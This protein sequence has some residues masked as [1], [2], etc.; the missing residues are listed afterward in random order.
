MAS[1]PSPRDPRQCALPSKAPS[2]SKAIQNTIQARAPPQSQ[3][4]AM[5]N[6]HA[7]VGGN[8]TPHHRNG[9]GGPTPSS[10][11]SSAYKS[12]SHSVVSSDYELATPYVNAAYPIGASTKNVNDMTT[13]TQHLQ[14]S[15]TSEFSARKSSPPMAASH[16]SSFMSTARYQE[17]KLGSQTGEFFRVNDENNPNDKGNKINVGQEQTLFDSFT[18][19]SINSSEASSLSIH[20]ESPLLQQQEQRWGNINVL[21]NGQNNVEAGKQTELL[22]LRTNPLSTGPTTIDDDDHSSITNSLSPSRTSGRNYGNSFQLEQHQDRQQIV[23]VERPHLLIYEQNASRASNN[24]NNNP[25][26][27]ADAS[28]LHSKIRSLDTQHKD[29]LSENNALASQ[30]KLD[31]QR[32]DTLESSEEEARQEAALWEARWRDDFGRHTGGGDESSP[33]LIEQLRGALLQKSKEEYG[34]LRREFVALTSKLEKAKGSYAMLMAENEALRE[35]VREA[36]GTGTMSHWE[37]RALDSEKDLMK[38][39]GELHQLMKEKRALE[40]RVNQLLEKSERSRK[41]FD[42][43]QKKLDEQLKNERDVHETKM[44]QITSEAAQMIEEETSKKNEELV[45]AKQ[46]NIVLKEENKAAGA[47]NEKLAERVVD[48]ERKIN[49]SLSDASDLRNSL[50]DAETAIPRLETE[51]NN[52]REKVDKLQND[53]SLYLD[54]VQALSSENGRLKLLVPRLEEQVTT[55][56]AENESLQRDNSDMKSKI[57]EFERKSTNLKSDNLA[58]KQRLDK[59]LEMVKTLQQTDSRTSKENSLLR[60]SIDGLEHKL[61]TVEAHLSDEREKVAF[62]DS[63]RDEAEEKASQFESQVKRLE[64]DLSAANQL[65]ANKRE[66]HLQL[67]N[68]IQELKKNISS[69]REEISAA[70]IARSQLELELKQREDECSS[71]RCQLDPTLKE[72]YR[73][74]LDNASLIE[75]IECLK[76]SI[77]SNSSLAAT[78]WGSEEPPES[79]INRLEEKN[80][81]LTDYIATLQKDLTSMQLSRPE[82]K[83]T[84]NESPMIGNDGTDTT[85]LLPADVLEQLKDA[86]A[87][88]KQTA[89][90]LS[91]QREE[92]IQMDATPTQSLVI[93]DDSADQCK[94]AVTNTP[95]QQSPKHLSSLSAN[96]V[97]SP[98]HAQHNIQ[99]GNND[100][101][102]QLE[103][104]HSAEKSVLKSKFQGRLRRMKKEWDL[105]R[106]AILGLVANNAGVDLHRGSTPSNNA[107]SNMQQFS[108]DNRLP[109][110]VGEVHSIAS[111]FDETEAFVLNILNGIEL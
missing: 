29:L 66:E 70:A 106:K 64:Y 111:S 77:A 59:E 19:D 52:L 48:L 9:N 63:A 75:E 83:P 2:R 60:S 31:Q 87:A 25:S 93:P 16:P 5:I 11:T 105:E 8:R 12:N 39:K 7:V 35:E 49:A 91:E 34:V 62:A 107:Q 76:K 51:R 102:I 47:E 54:K 69:L 41:E 21:L 56:L 80:L 37:R 110:A 109:S 100:I 13:S 86:R 42:A 17:Q 95:H 50:L 1:S 108:S 72:K 44:K 4:D 82:T 36:G 45:A 28:P 94:H 67:E 26:P 32:I 46:E 65:N 20:D 73:L 98:E 99:H 27:L 6:R 24:E 74:E 55:A 18:L 81:A 22:Q 71:L 3:A 23:D 85:P 15:M 38:R 103:E 89:L 61:I 90:F 88:A 33:L 14:N 101:L 79:I 53:Y 30:L 78:E 92:C 10:L 68:N 104:R 97:V 43:V 58:L 96:T 84:P 40:E 57:N